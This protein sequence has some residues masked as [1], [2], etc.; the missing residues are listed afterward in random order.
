M[1]RVI[2]T[3]VIA[4]AF[5]AQAAAQVNYSVSGT[6]PDSLNGR[7]VY[8]YEEE[9][10]NHLVDSTIVRKGRFHFKGSR[11]EPVAA[12]LYIGKRPSRQEFAFVLD[13]VPVRLSL[14]GG[15]KV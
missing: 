3:V 13:E 2:L 12:R 6:V 9:I 1:K 7:K 8:L 14:L 5:V 10:K 11:K 4:V 15:K